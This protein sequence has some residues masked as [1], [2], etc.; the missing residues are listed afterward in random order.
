MN[1]EVHVRFCESLG[2]KFPR[3]TRHVVRPQDVSRVDREGEQA[4]RTRS[5]T[6]VADRSTCASRFA[7]TALGLR[8]TR[9]CAWIAVL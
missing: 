4:D 5:L 2:V 3:A 6:C 1:R 8:S 7:A 9:S